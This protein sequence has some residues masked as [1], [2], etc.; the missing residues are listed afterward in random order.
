MRHK[1]P[2][3][4]WDM[5]D[6]ASFIIRETEGKS[7]QDLESTPLLRLAVERQFEILGEA[8]RRLRDYDPEVANRIPGIHDAIGVRN[9]IAREY[10]DV[11]YHVLWGT[12]QGPLRDLE[13]A[14]R[15]LLNEHGPPG[16]DSS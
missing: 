15:A 8:A 9:V 11:N 16:S 5:Q 1:S 2:K 12:I 14:T 7:L 4:L 13:A 6:A 10:D 3:W